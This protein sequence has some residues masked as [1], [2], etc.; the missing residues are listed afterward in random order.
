[1]YA[2]RRLL[3]HESGAYGDTTCLSGL[4]GSSYCCDQATA[5]LNN[6]T[7]CAAGSGRQGL[8][9][10][11]GREAKLDLEFLESIIGYSYNYSGDHSAVHGRFM[12]GRGSIDSTILTRPR[13]APSSFDP[14]TVTVFGFLR[15]RMPCNIFTTRAQITFDDVA[16]A[17]HES[18]PAGAWRSSPC[19]RPAAPA[20]R[21]ATRHVYPAAAAGAFTRPRFSSSGTSLDTK[22][23][24]DAPQYPPT[25]PRRSLSN[26]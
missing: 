7:Y 2:G 16:S 6:C 1:M 5:D 18:L 26:L 22:Y 4:C 14:P 15:H 11:F 9:T 23:T 20:P 19:S 25:P 3:S 17:I 12:C 8:T 24:L 13:H 10:Q 21:P